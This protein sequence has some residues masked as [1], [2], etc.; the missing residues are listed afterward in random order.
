MQLAS[1]IENNEG[2]DGTGNQIKKDIYN[3]V[4]SGWTK[5]K[6]LESAWICLV[7]FVLK[8]QQYTDA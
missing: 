4:T 3:A 2:S 5:M 1:F 6:L 7:L 8:N